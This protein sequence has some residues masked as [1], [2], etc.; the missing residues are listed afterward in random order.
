MHDRCGV[1]EAVAD[2]TFAVTLFAET[3]ESN[4]GLLATHNEIGVMLCHDVALELCERLNKKE[5]RKMK[6]R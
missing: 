5:K 4:T 3:A 2:D 6:R 1:H